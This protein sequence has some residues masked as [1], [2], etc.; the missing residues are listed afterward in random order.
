MR[1]PTGPP[2]EDSERDEKESEKKVGKPEDDRAT[3]G[4]SVAREIV[5]RV[6]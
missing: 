4:S 6:K 3:I 1:I 2:F 5:Y